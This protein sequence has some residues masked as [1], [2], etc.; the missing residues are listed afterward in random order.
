MPSEGLFGSNTA[1]NLPPVMF[2]EL[3]GTFALVWAGTT[4]AVAATLQSPIA[5]APANSLAVALS[6]GV[7][8]AAMVAT[9]G[10]ISGSHLNPAVTIGLAYKRQFPWKYV[11]PYIAM[12]FLGAV[13]ASL[14]VGW[15]YGDEAKTEAALGATQPAPDVGI[16]DVFSMEML[17]TFLLVLVIY[18][19]GTDKRVPP[20]VAPFAIGSTL[21]FA[22]MAIGPRTGGGL[23]PARA[24]GPM[25]V[26]GQWNEAWYMYLAGP[27]VGGVLAAIV[28]SILRGATKPSE[29]E[30]S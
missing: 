1:T 5:G 23:N 3:I 26:S 28:Y 10:H 17:A 4:A 8:L 20:A 12:Q 19:V 16:W 25:I 13:L 11:F 24:L 29:A 27:L 21:F 9:F 15:M 22:I 14:V 7:A 30:K 6:F 2:A 18:S